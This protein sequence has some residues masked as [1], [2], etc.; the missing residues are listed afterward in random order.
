MDGQ[1]LALVGPSDLLEQLHLRSPRHGPHGRTRQQPAGGPRRRPWVGP[2]QM[3]TTA[4]GGAKTGEHTHAKLRLDAIGA[5]A[6][7]RATQPGYGLVARLGLTDA[8]G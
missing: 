7:D 6:L 2:N 5:D 4:S 8:K 1:A 3:S